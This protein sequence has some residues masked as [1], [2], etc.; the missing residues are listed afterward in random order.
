M[1]AQFQEGYK[2]V[3]ILYNIKII[4][5]EACG[6]LHVT[7]TSSLELPS[8]GSILGIGVTDTLDWSTVAEMMQ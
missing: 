7:L 1:F 4:P 2:A 3:N 8:V 5:N 6:S